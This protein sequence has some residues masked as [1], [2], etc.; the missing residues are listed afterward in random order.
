[1]GKRAGR[2]GTGKAVEGRADREGAEV[3]GKGRALGKVWACGGGEGCACVCGGWGDG[4][5]SIGVVCGRTGIK[6]GCER[7]WVVGCSGLEEREDT[8][9]GQNMGW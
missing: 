8:G 3:T 2:D 1:M 4:G 7:G 5:L 9:R 6:N